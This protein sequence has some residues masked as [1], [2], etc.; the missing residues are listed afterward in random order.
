MLT[1]EIQSGS[2]IL[3]DPCYDTNT[4]CQS[5]LYN[6]KKGMYGALAIMDPKSNRVKSLM[7]YNLSSLFEYPD[8]CELLMSAPPLPQLGGVDSGQFGFFDLNHYRKNDSI[9][10]AKL[11]EFMD[12]KEEGEA[13]Y[14]ACCY[15]TCDSTLK[16]GTLPYG[17]VSS[18]GWGDGAYTLKAYKDLNGEYIGFYVLFIDDIFLDDDN[19]DEE[20]D[21]EE[22]EDTEENQ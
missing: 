17:V 22:E 9:G 6:V 7:A 11:A 5:I 10:N 12:S 16:Y 20:D 1:F 18:S 21:T 14:S 8:I 2:I 19:I 13:F 15:H 3:T 4:W